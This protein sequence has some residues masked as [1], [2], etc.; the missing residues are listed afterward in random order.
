MKKWKIGAAIGAVWGLI[1]LPV[2]S[3]LGKNFWVEMTIIEKLLILPFTAATYIF[4]LFGLAQ[5]ADLQ[6][7]PIGW[8]VE[9]IIGIL[10]GA[11][12]GHLID[13]YKSKK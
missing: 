4:H 10:I 6:I 9:I 5:G 12:V 11:G 7:H 3:W 2:F 13:K 8:G 1:S